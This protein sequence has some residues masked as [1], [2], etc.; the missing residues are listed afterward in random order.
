MRCASNAETLYVSIVSSVPVVVSDVSYLCFLLP[1][2]AFH[3]GLSL[4]ALG[5]MSRPRMKQS[6]SFWSSSHSRWLMMGYEEE[7]RRISSTSAY[8]ERHRYM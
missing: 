1:F 8:M 7:R 5:M 6:I 2:D 3:S 4:S